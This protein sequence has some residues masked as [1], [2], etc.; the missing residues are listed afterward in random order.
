M[1][2]LQWL[3]NRLAADDLTLA[4]AAVVRAQVLELLSDSDPG[5][6]AGCGSGS[7]TVVA[8]RTNDGPGNAFAR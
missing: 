5:G 4:E 1:E 6:G 7:A 2:R 8:P 3:L